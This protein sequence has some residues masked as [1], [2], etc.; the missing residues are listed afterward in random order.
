MFQDIR[1]LEYSKDM[2]TWFTEKEIAARKG[3]HI[4]DYPFIRQLF[5]DG[6]F[7]V[8]DRRKKTDILGKRP[9]GK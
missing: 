5:S 4:T 7:T 1:N 6:G 3:E 2:K 8:T 9:D